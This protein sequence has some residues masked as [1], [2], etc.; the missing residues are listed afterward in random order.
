MDLVSKFVLYR[1]WNKA[2]AITGFDP[3][4][5]RKDF[6]G[7]W[8]RRDAFGKQGKYGWVIDHLKPKSIGGT[9]DLDNLNALH[10]MNNEEKG[11]SYPEFC[12]S[13]SSDG[14]RNIESKKKWQ[15]VSKK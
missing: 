7:A 3:D 10:W 2:K 1:V 8:I 6:A 15:I 14:N 11:I 5:W 9:D 4:I 12:T 13:L